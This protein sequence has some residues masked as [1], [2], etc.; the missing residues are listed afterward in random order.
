MRV[1]VKVRVRVRV[2]VRVMVT[3]PG[4]R[5]RTPHSF[6]MASFTT[7]G[8]VNATPAAIIF[9]PTFGHGIGGE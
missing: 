8:D 2:R 1:R 6:E 7:V 9:F 3:Q 4:D 5:L